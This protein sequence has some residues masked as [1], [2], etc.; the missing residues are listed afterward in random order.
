MK[1]LWYVPSVVCA[2]EAYQQ[3]ATFKTCLIPAVLVVAAI[4]FALYPT[5]MGGE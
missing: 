3:H 1:Y 5:M 2:I 4:V